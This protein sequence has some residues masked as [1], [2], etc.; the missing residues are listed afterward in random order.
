MIINT[1]SP[2][3]FNTLR[4]NVFLLM[5]TYP[6]L[7]LS[8]IGYSVLGLPLYCIRF[9]T[10]P[11]EI[12]YSASIHANEWITSPV[13]MKFVEDLCIAYS[14]NANIYGYSANSIF[15]TT[16]IYIVPMVNPDGVNLVTS[17]LN[18]N[19]NSYMYAQYIANKYPD[20][21]FPSGWK[22]N[23]N[24]VDLKIYQPFFKS[25]KFLA[26]KTFLIFILD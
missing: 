7:K 4:D 9:G 11:K 6:F 19:S 14:H 17:S 20:I 15:E 26:Y 8:T 1:N 22:A 21:S 10:G 3:N 13:L 18:K 23:I 2:Y 24:G 25:C 16:S 12:F 5:T